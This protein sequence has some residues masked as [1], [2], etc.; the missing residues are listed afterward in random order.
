VTQFLLLGPFE[1]HACRAPVVVGPPKQ[2]TLLAAL[3]LAAGRPVTAD[4][5]I[6][7]VWGGA[8][9]AKARANLHAYVTRL[10]GCLSGL[11]PAAQLERRS[12]GYLLA[13][14]PDLVDLHVFRRLVQEAQAQRA[15]PDRNTLA[16]LRHALGMW[17]G[18]PLAD[19]P[20]VWAD[21]VR[22]GLAQT[23]LAALLYWSDLELHLG[24][25]D[26]VVTGLTELVHQYPLVEPLTA[27]LIRALRLT[28]RNAEALATYRATRHRLVEALG[29]DPGPELR[30]LYHA[31]L[32]GLP[33]AGS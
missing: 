18:T 25:P 26:S 12:A 1:V 9:P 11:N 24:E 3:L 23:R 22:E 19:L 4:A 31:T 5:L 17:R 32:H 20:G 15:S 7:R 6:D 29:V 2:R 10:R 30:E 13:V 16:T 28:N 8:P 27:A 14:D 33:A 21:Q